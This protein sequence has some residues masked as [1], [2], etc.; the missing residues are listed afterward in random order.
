M[1]LY[2]QQQNYPSFSNEGHLVGC[3]HRYR[4][5]SLVLALDGLVGGAA[6]SSGC[7]VFDDKEAAVGQFPALQDNS[8]TY[9]NALSVIAYLS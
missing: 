6:A 8:R 4:Q 7:D 2:L 1:G 9:R 3:T 5:W